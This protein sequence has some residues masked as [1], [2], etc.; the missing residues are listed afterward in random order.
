MNCFKKVEYSLIIY[1]CSF[2]LSSVRTS[3][4]FSS[5]RASWACSL[6]AVLDFLSVMT[7]G[8]LRL[9]VLIGFVC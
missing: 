6:L 8:L 4:A 2:G 9:L 3:A 1:S 7:S 5:I